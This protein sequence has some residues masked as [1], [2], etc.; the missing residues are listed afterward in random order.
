MTRSARTLRTADNLLRDLDKA[1]STAM[2]DGNPPGPV[3]VEIPTDVLRKRVPPRTS[4]CT[5]TSRRRRRA[6]SRRIP[7]RS[8]ARPH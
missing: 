5:N 2:G 4:C 1:W 3:Y 7:P 6:A 8:L